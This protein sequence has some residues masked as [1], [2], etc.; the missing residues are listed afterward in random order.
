MKKIGCS[1]FLILLSFVVFSQQ[2]ETQLFEQG[3]DQFVY[4][5]SNGT[6]FL[7]HQVLR[8]P[9][10]SIS[11]AEKIF[12]EFNS[13]D[14]KLSKIILNYHQNPMW[15][16]DLE[17]KKL[18]TPNIKFTKEPQKTLQI[19][20]HPDIRSRFGYYSDPYEVKLSMVIDSRIYIL[21]GLSIIG[22]LSLPINNNLDNQSMRIRPAP[23]MLHY[24]T[25]IASNNFFAL[26]MGSFYGDNYGI[27]MEYRHANWNLNW[28]YGLNCSWTGKYRFDGFTY[29]AKSINTFKLIADVETRI[30]TENMSLKLSTGQWLTGDQGA[31]LDIIKQF[32]TTD[33]GF[34]GS[35]SP[36]GSSF[37]FQFAVNLF[38]SI[39]LRSKRVI[40]RS[41]EEFR[42]EYVFNSKSSSTKNFRKSLPR[43][44]DL[45]RQYNFNFRTSTD[46]N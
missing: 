16:Y 20:L 30:A 18:F 8:T 26:S 25:K 2:F 22:G 28:S 38:P 17:Q 41:S 34:F 33:I 12:E 13:T 39:I 4:D 19:R 31:R 21:K 1:F 35:Y 42:F 10:F 24:M 9:I 5:E 29:N 11:L 46:L 43:L 7:E 37:G 45:L 6:L 44:D 36:Q 23:S 15:G 27:D 14:L 3:Y 40:L 32:N